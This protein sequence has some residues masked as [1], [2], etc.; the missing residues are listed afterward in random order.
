MK[1]LTTTKLLIT[2]IMVVIS[3]V[4]TIAQLSDSASISILTCR[5]GDEVWNTF[6]HNAIWVVDPITKKSEIYNYGLFNFN[7]P[8]FTIKFLRGK[9][10]YAL[11]IQRRDSFLNNYT[12]EERTVLLQKL[13]LNT[14]QRN[15]LYLGL[16]ENY[17]PK[18]RKYLYD[19]FFDNCSTRPRDLLFDNLDGLEDISQEENSKTF[20]KLLDEYTYGSPW[21]DFGIDLIIGKKADKIANK[22]DQM[23]LPEYLYKRLEGMEINDEPLVAEQSI[24]LDY[25]KEKI[26]RQQRHWLTP[27][28]VFGILLFFHLI[29]LNIRVSPKNGKVVRFYDNVWIFLAGVGGCVVLF[30]W[31]GTDHIATKDNLNLLWLNP[32]FLVFLFYRKKWFL[33]V[34]MFCLLAALIVSVTI[35]KF[36]IASILIICILNFTLLRVLRTKRLAL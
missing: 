17:K 11:G 35:Q 36:H 10:L 12:I 23:F 26:E 24:I 9:L 1:I 5:Q 18:N 15:K 25:E 2:A 4:S 32:L 20:R 13:N 27:T 14:D 30:M 22:D 8:N 29:L 34:L 7:E 19:F 21:M 6:G 28:L 3:F 31:I 16:R 33:I